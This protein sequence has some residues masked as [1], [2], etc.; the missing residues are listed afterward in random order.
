MLAQDPNQTGRN[1]LVFAVVFNLKEDNKVSY[2][3]TFL[4]ETDKEKSIKYLYR[5]ASLQGPNYTPTCI[6]GED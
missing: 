5:R 6:T 4:E 3:H 2:S 1:P